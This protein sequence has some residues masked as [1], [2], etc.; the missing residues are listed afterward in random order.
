MLRK[1]ANYT[2][3]HPSGWSRGVKSWF[4]VLKGRLW[5]DSGSCESSIALLTLNSCSSRE[6]LSPNQIQAWQYYSN[7]GEDMGLG[8]RK[9]LTWGTNM[10]SMAAHVKPFWHMTWTAAFT[11]AF[12]FGL[13]MILMWCNLKLQLC[14]WTALWQQLQQPTSTAW[15]MC[16]L[17]WGEFSHLRLS[18][19][20]TG[21]QAG[22]K[23]DAVTSA[24][25]GV[26]LCLQA[27]GSSRNLGLCDYRIPIPLLWRSEP[28]W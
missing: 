16:M 11:L 12:A 6:L 27:T 25:A 5:A 22:Q 9:I 7:V 14:T 24:K 1:A 15:Q 26:A 28:D 2:M 23:T 8:F 19:E 18:L 17:S 13:E 10:N 4:V 3:H 21:A 20:N